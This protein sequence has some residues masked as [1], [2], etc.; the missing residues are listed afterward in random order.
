MYRSDSFDVTIVSNA[1]G[2]LV[3]HSNVVE[4][5]T[6]SIIICFDQRSPGSVCILYAECRESNVRIDGNVEVEQ[7][8]RAP[9]RAA[10][11]PRESCRSTTAITGCTIVIRPGHATYEISGLQRVLLSVR[12]LT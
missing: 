3:Q 9:E 10:K 5:E 7:R 2:R 11:E 8:D 4:G 6:S 1:A 12:Q